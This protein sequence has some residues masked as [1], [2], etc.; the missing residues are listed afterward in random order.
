MI[1]MGKKLKDNILLM[2][3]EWSVHKISTP[4]VPPKYAPPPRLEGVLILGTPMNVKHD[5]IAVCPC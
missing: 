4:F 5:Y 1:S 2:P 3:K